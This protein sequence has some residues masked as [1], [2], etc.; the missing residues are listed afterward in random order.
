MDQRKHGRVRTF[1]GSNLYF[2]R[3]ILWSIV[4][5]G[6]CWHCC[7]SARRTSKRTWWNKN[8]LWQQFILLTSYSLKHCFSWH[9][10]ALFRNHYFGP[11]SNSYSHK[12]NF[13]KKKSI[14]YS[15]ILA[16]IRLLSSNENK[17]YISAVTFKKW[18]LYSLRNEGLPVQV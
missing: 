10:L 3:P 17:R 15:N 4:T 6:T 8:Y 5:L 12:W 18:Q 2:W 13:Y 7:C 9:W 14:L 1:S 16:I 11:M